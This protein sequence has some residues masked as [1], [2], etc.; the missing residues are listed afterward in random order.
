MEIREGDLEEIQKERCHR[1]FSDHFKTQWGK[2]RQYAKLGASN[3]IFGFFN[4]I[5]KQKCISNNWRIRAK[6]IQDTKKYLHVSLAQDTSL[7]EFCLRSAI[8]RKD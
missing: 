1:S 2:I 3:H 4:F 8:T 7:S 5:P 6:M